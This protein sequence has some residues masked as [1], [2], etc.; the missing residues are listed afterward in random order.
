MTTEASDFLETRGQGVPVVEHGGPDLRELQRLGLDPA[1]ILDFSV[2]TNPYGP[3]PRVYEALRQVAVDL[4]P[5]RDAGVL[6]TI[7][8]EMHGIDHR[9]IL[10]GNGVSELI[11][12]T[13]LA[14]VRPRQ[15]VLVVGPTYG[16]YARSALL[17]G[18][19]VGSWNARERQHF[20][21]AVQDIESE[22]R[23]AEPR[24]VF[25]CNPNNPTGAILAPEVILSWS[26]QHPRTLFV[27]DEAYQGFAPGL[28][29]LVSSGQKNLLILRSMTK[30]YALAGLRVGYA[31]SSVEVIAG[32][33]D[34]RP[35]WS[36]SALAQAAAVAALDDVSHRDRSLQA[37]VQAKHLLVH[38]LAELDLPVLPSASHFF[39]VRVKDSSAF[40]LALLS[41]NILV[42]DAASFGLPGFVRL[43][44]RL[45]ED[46]AR[47]LAALRE[48]SW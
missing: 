33:S 15:R 42:R 27:V 48:V 23:S 32:L 21:P 40:R 41:R 11:W 45:P 47:L 4:Y 17:H 25:L 9:Q 10:A 13:A 46:N 5:D 37:L 14:F 3:S 34:V 44:T 20:Q 7:L 29:S 26:R 36:V 30:D 12:L 1:R 18:A 8:A 38:G 35:P 2:C 28:A 16:E 6:G 31:V 24:L 43:A 39:L 19:R 22:L